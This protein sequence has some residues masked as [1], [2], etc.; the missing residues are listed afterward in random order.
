MIKINLLPVRDIVR[1]KKYLNEIIAAS[2]AFGFIICILVIVELFQQSSINELN[3][4]VAKIESEKKKFSAILTE[5][6]KLDEEKKLLTTRTEVINQLKQSSSLTV[7]VLDE[8]AN[9]TPPNRM[10][11][12]SL[13]QNG[14]QLA[15]TGMAL[16]DQTIARYMD[17]LDA[18]GYIQNV[19][20]ASSSLEVFAERSLKAF[21]ITANTEMPKKR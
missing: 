21:S 18:S 6:K 16:D 5:I 7:H 13:S 2:F 11:L 14:N 15:L 8:I 10:W 4:N 1:R 20:L 19:R 12:K 9:L 3:E 17:D